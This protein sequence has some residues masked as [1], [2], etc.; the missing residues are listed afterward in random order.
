M[1]HIALAMQNNG[2]I[3][4]CNVCKTSLHVNDQPSNIDKNKIYEFWNSKTRQEIISDL[5]NGKIHSGCKGCFEKETTGNISS[6]INFN[7]LF[8]NLSHKPT[9]QVL[10]MKP[11]N[12]CNSA[13]RT[14]V[15]ETSSSLYSDF[16]K[17]HNEKN[18][19]VKFK[20]YIK[21]FEIIRNSF[22]EDNPNFWPSVNE[23]Y[24]TLH[25]M[26]VYG[27][28]PWLIPGLWKSLQYSVD[29][30]FAK[31]ISIQFHTNAMTW[32]EKY[33]DILKNFKHIKIGLS[34]DSHIKEEFN[35]LRHK[36]NYNMVMENSKKFINY[37]NQKNNMSVYISVTPSILNIWNL[38]EIVTN[39]EKNFNID[40]GFTNFVY[41]PK[42]Y[43]IRHLPREVK[44]LIIDK[45]KNTKLEKVSDFMNS[46]IQG[47]E[48][49]W[50]KFCME[51]DKFDR[52]RNQSFA[53]T[54]PEWYA[55]LK[56][57]WDYK[58]RHS[59]WYGTV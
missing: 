54:F 23:W 51:T 11:G 17:L 52:I 21:K 19:Q 14:C 31:N 26:D 58:K 56:P 29:N 24:K 39:L 35:Y 28:E 46:P 48:I 1:P 2:D 45:F 8:A 37:I 15:P 38:D 13:C 32:N 40:V 50:P 16:Y 57:Y 34:L 30:D 20:D 47:C 53:L 12:T 18:T 3:S 22:N 41:E 49:Y 25:Y 44:K 55:I 27:G 59:D 9:P 5:D 6:R 7:E 43:D 10:I 36:S 33:L 42:H 4:V